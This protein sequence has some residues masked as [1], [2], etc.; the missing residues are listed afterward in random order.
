MSSRN[1]YLTAEQRSQAPVLYRSLRW[2][3]ERIEA[4]ERRA[5]TLIEGMTGMIA[6]Q[7]AAQ[8]DYIAIVDTK[9]LQPVETLRGEVLI[10]LAVRF[11]R[12]RLIDNITIQVEGVNE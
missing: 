9:E 7:P 1:E 11:G 12:A 2:A 10:A 8:V 4:G 5:G 3:Q 6:G